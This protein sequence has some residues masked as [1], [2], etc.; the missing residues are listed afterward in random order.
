[1]NFKLMIYLALFLALTAFNFKPFIAELITAVP[2]E[3]VKWSQVKRILFN[4]GENTPLGKKFID[5]VQKD[6]N[7]L[8]E[9]LSDEVILELTKSSRGL[10]TLKK[11]NSGLL[12][13]TDDLSKGLIRNAK[14]MELN[15]KLRPEVD[16]TLRLKLRL[17]ENKRNDI[18]KIVAQQTKLQ[19]INP[20]EALDLLLEIDSRK[21]EGALS[22]PL[23]VSVNRVLFP[24]HLVKHEGGTAQKLLTNTTPE[25][26]K[27]ISEIAG[28]LE[29]N[30]AWIQ[31]NLSEGQINKIFPSTPAMAPKY[32]AVPPQK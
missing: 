6:K 1:M 13:A 8:K 28:T 27:G 17:I 16:E 10:L 20:E 7:F 26:E 5:V 30:N 3:N 15:P 22:R 11:I 12:M 23:P 2:P 32:P 4:K 29:R 14:E 31:K 24:D 21:I 19:K 25:A 9:S 18:A